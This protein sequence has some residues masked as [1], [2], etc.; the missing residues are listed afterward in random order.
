MEKERL[1][2]EKLNKE[3]LLNEIDSKVKSLIDRKILEKYI[4]ID[5]DERNIKLA[6]SYLADSIKA[7]ISD[8]NLEIMRILA[9]IKIKI[10]DNTIT[11]KNADK[12]I[13]KINIER[14]VFS[15][16][17]D[18]AQQHK[19]HLLILNNEIDKIVINFDDITN[20]KTKNEK[21][22]SQYEDQLLALNK[23]HDKISKTISDLTSELLNNNLV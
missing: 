1:K 3:N 12:A 18:E 13:E 14:E 19:E 8:E 6:K 5:V 9:E 15:N 20:E 21:K 2:E 16:L 4:H 22:I 10:N 17:K 23:K 11:L 7:L